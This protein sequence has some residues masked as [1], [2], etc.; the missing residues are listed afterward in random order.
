MKLLPEVSGG[1]L[2]T[3][4]SAVLTRG[5]ISQAADVSGGTT[6]RQKLVQMC[7]GAAEG[8]GEMWG[9]RTWTGR[10]GVLQHGARGVEGDP[11][12]A[13]GRREGHRAAV[14]LSAWD[15]AQSPSSALVS[16]PVL[17]FLPAAPPSEGSAPGTGLRCARPGEESGR[18]Q[19][20][21]Q[22]VLGGSEGHRG[23]PG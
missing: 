18:T 13:S 10:L 3:H 4:V 19:G 20:A 15:T 6:L 16:T 7:G 11:R 22:C 2:R 17:G 9:P 21:R 1:G 14:R 23:P 5:G 12:R 8:Q